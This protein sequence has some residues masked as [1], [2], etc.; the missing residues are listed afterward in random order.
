M[1]GL[2]I[3]AVIYLGVASGCS[4]FLYAATS[5]ARNR[6]ARMDKAADAEFIVKQDQQLRELRSANRKL[7]GELAERQ[8]LHAKV[9]TFAEE[10]VLRAIAAERELCSTKK[11]LATALATADAARRDT[12]RIPLADEDSL[13]RIPPQNLPIPLQPIPIQPPRE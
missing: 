8:S 9:M 3:M 13:E 12:T 6:D 4:V 5:W 11:Q 10:Q 2:L 1:R 7:Q